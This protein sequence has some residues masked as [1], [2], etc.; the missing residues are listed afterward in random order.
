[1]S[2]TWGYVKD[3]AL[4]KLDLDETEANNQNFLSR[5][6]YYANEAMTQICS[7][8]KPKYTYVEFNITKDLVGVEQKMPDDFISFG[9]DI[10]Y[11]LLNDERMTM[12]KEIHDSD[13]TYQGYNK[14][15][16]FREGRFFISYNA[17]WFMFAKNINNSVVLDAP[18]DVIECLAAYIASQCYKIDDEYRASIFRNEYEVL[19]ARI[20]NTN[21]KNTKTFIIEGDW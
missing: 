5:F 13:F 1:M 19:L 11:E 10:N 7:S 2:Y 17:R 14:V 18:D 9:D 15:V 20:D 21:Y 16:F 4:A 3:N 12:K 8:V 6:P